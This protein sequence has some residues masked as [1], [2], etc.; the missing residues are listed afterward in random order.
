MEIFQV[1]QILQL[2]PYFDGFKKDNSVNLDRDRL[3]N[4]IRG[5][6]GER[7][8]KISEVAISYINKFIELSEDNDMKLIF[9][10]T[11]VHRDYFEKI[12]KVFLEKYAGI[13][14][15]LEQKKNIYFLD[16]SNLKLE[17]KYYLNYD[18]TNLSGAKIVSEK[19]NTFLKQELE[20]E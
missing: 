16:Y 4:T 19:L 17:D 10:N 6:Y 2:V 5:H 1:I 15:D 20:N 8:Y 11:P 18:H 12:P 3:D 7:N 14:N 9:I 13:Q